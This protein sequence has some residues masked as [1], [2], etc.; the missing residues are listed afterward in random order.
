[1]QIQIQWVQVGGLR[2]SPSNQ[3]PGKA[4]ALARKPHLKSQR[5]TEPAVNAY[6]S[7][8]KHTPFPSFWF[9]TLGFFWEQSPSCS[10]F[11]CFGSNGPQCS[12]RK[13]VTWVCSIPDPGHC[14]RLEAGPE[15]HSQGK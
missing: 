8:P 5:P 14:G 2:F 15:T 4:H 7:P 3:P 10:L 11:A 13:Q 6:H 1:M 12:G 9:Q